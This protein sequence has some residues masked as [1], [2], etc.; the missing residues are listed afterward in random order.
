MSH[1]FSAELCDSAAERDP[2][3]N[4]DVVQG[5]TAAV[6]DNLSIQVNYSSY[7]TKGESGHRIEMTNWATM[8]LPNRAMPKGFVGMDSVLSNGGIFRQDVAIDDFVDRFSQY[9]AMIIRNQRERWTRTG[10]SCKALP[11]LGT[12]GDDCCHASGPKVA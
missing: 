4:Y 11:L 9:D 5:I 12:I 2:G 1:D 6:F 7:M 10:A 8:F 3:P